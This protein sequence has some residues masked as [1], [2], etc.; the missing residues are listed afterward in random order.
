M[1]DPDWADPIGEPAMTDVNFD[2]DK[3]ISENITRSENL[4]EPNLNDNN[5]KVNGITTEPLIE[6]EGEPEIIPIPLDRDES[7]NEGGSE[8]SDPPERSKIKRTRANSRTREQVLKRYSTT[9]VP[10]VAEMTR[11][12]RRIKAPERLNL[13]VPSSK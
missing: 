10:K 8:S 11:S 7:D 12:G 2:V 5:S 1:S 4:G 13:A 6:P 9:S 3:H